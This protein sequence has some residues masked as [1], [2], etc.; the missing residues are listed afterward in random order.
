MFVS[1]GSGT[2]KSSIGIRPMGQTDTLQTLT[3]FNKTTYKC[4]IG[5]EN[6]QSLVGLLPGR[7]QS[8]VVLNVVENQGRTSEWE[9]SAEQQLRSQDLEAAHGHHT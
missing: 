9:S 8:M 5:N 2:R 3:F 7:A 1:R 6:P 4:G